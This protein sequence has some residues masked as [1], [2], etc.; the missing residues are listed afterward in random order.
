MPL[1]DHY[2]SPQH[3]PFNQTALATEFSLES[4][5]RDPGGAGAWVLLHGGELLVTDGPAP[6]LPE[7]ALPPV[8]GGEPVYIGRYRGQPCRALALPREAPLPAGLHGESL[9]AADP[10]LSLP[11][12]SLA[13]TAGQILH[14]LKNSRFCD[15]CGGG[16]MPVPG[17]WG[18]R[19][20]AC[21]Y[22]HFPH[23]HP[24]IIVL[25]RRGSELLLTRKAE[26]PQG[27]YSLVAGFLDVGECLEEAVH[28]E[29][30]EETGV[31]VSNVRYV[32]SQ[33][34]PF[35]SQLMAGFVADYAGGELRVEEAELED[36]RWFSIDALPALP[37][38]RSIARY[39]L[40]HFGTPGGA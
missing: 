38:K 23:I 15:R 11:L 14:W 2:S 13:G 17:G 1:P 16:T 20:D 26:W 34:W 37:P 6:A 36:A 3:L 27:R 33:C 7:G 31:R 35:P 28:R 9:L 24:C 30:L 22:T 4:P 39:I 32:G 8:A 12:M 40:D 10:A 29:V 25:V 18:R 5:E 19:C 21:G